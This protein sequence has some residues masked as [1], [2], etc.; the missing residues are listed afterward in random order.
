MHNFFLF[1]YYFSC[2]LTDCISS[3]Y[4]WIKKPPIYIVLYQNQTVFIF[5]FLVVVV[6]F[7]FFWCI[8]TN[9][10]YIKYQIKSGTQNDGIWLLLLWFFLLLLWCWAS[11]FFPSTNETKNK[12]VIYQYEPWAN[13]AYEAW[14]YE[15]WANGAYAAWAL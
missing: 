2:F 14:P 15:A 6:F 3:A 5:L 8:N 11:C 13:G 9:R 7:R 12:M 10:I 1:Y 4:E